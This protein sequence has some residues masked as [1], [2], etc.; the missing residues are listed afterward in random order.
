[1]SLRFDGQAYSIDELAK[2]VKVTDAKDESRHVHCFIELVYIL[3]GRSVQNVDGV[4]YPVSR[5]NLLL[6]NE[7]QQHSMVCHPGTDYIN[8]LMKPQIISESIAQTANAFS[9]LA[10]KDFSEFKNTVDRSNCCVRFE[11]DERDR[12][13]MLLL[14]LL[15]EQKENRSGG[16]LML[17]SGL[18]M[19][20]IQVFRKMALPMHP[21]N[22]KIDH[23]LLS[24]L[25]KHCAEKISL[26]DV[27]EHCGYD[28]SYFSRLF[29][30]TTGKNFTD[31][32]TDCRIDK[33]CS[34]LEETMQSVDSIIVTCG[35]SDRTKFFRQFAQRTG[36]T[37]LKYRKSKNQ[38]L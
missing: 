18:N 31:Y 26:E 34:L 11:G 36:F 23:L 30:R 8:V 38:I 24:Y 10:L 6:I 19:L 17:R 14:W 1:M 16:D 20:L 21:A 32:I 9:L 5:G 37:P 4:E 7:S 3:R 13:E 25:Q 28:P 15:R 12:M 35:F 33:A 29:K 22:Q 2:V 27:A